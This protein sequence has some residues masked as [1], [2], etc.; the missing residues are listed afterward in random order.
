MTV[1]ALH[2]STSASRSL[3]YWRIVYTYPDSRVGRQ[4]D[5]RRCDDTEKALALAQRTSG[6]VNRGMIL[7][8]TEHH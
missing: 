3:V 7:S 4:P 6:E 5:A 2:T 1:V 8:F